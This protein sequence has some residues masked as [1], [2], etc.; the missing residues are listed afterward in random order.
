MT[1]LRTLVVLALAACVAACGITKGTKV[2]DSEGT[3]RVPYRAIALVPI[4]G[5]PEERAAF[6][7]ALAAALQARGVKTLS[8]SRLGAQVTSVD[9]TAVI[10]ALKAD[11]ADAVLYLWISRADK[12]GNGDKSVGGWG[13]TGQAAAWY[14]P[15]GNTGAAIGRFEARLYDL[16]NTQEVW[17]GRTMTFYPKTPAI[18]AP[19]VADA[20]VAEL[21]SRGYLG[22]AP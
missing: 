20:V 17:F 15:S 6:E 8:S 13:W 5:T 18:D 9:G 2:T 12:A 10:R 3:P 19:E 11:G 4:D 22:R 1:A 16:G 14:T 21:A 7:A